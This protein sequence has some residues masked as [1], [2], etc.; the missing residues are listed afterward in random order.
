MEALFRK[1][2]Y[3]VIH[4]REIFDYPSYTGSYTRTLKAIEEVLEENPSIQIVLDIQRDAI[5]KQA[6]SITGQSQSST[7]KQ[8]R[9]CS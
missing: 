5:V 4:I 1:R 3:E 8:R 7:V 9:Y 2:G 6:A